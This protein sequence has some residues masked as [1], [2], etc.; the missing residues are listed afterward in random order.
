MHLNTYG[1]ST[2]PALIILHGWGLDGSLYKTLAKQLANNWYVIVPDLPG[3]GKSE[4]PPKP[5]RLDDYL[6]EIKQ[7][8]K[9]QG[10]KEAVFVGHSFGG[11]LSMKMAVESPKLVKQLVLTGAPGVE[12]FA[13]KRSGK[14][15]VAWTA[16]KTL[17]YFTWIP[18]I[19]KVRQRFYRNRDLGKLEGV[20]AETFR[21]VI[22]EKLTKIAK[23]IQQPTLLVWGA[24]DQ[25]APVED[26]EKM[27]KIIPHSY[28]K[29]FTKVG[30]KLPYEKPHEFAQEVER[31]CL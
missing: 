28:L 16:A 30:H 13:W 23:K 12:R 11:R 29:I 31:F 8:L 18:P 5:Y 9:D 21:L 4:A 2:Q 10:V 3:F 15:L 7:L 20:M 26:A 17:K 24:K 14:R 19:K 6:K 22:A 25:M 27:L 1:K